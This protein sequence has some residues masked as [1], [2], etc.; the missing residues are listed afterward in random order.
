MI[1][2]VLIVAGVCALGV[3]LVVFGR[4]PRRDDTERFHRARAMTTEWSRTYAATGQLG[5]PR[6][7]ADDL[8]REREHADH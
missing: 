1:Y 8:E 3:A 4:E 5:L 2:V 6:T 7:P